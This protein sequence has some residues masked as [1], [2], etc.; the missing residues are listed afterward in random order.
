MNQCKYCGQNT[1]RNGYCDHCGAP[2]SITKYEKTLTDE[3]RR[4][5]GVT[6]T[7]VFPENNDIN[8][9]VLD[10]LKLKTFWLIV[11]VL[12]QYMIFYKFGLL[13][14]GNAISSLLVFVILFSQISRR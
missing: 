1:N 13:D 7:D 12:I 2:P 9:I 4:V 10:I 14:V 11:I 8:S 5:A 6:E 3:I